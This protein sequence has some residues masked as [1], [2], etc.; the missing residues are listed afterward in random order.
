MARTKGKAKV[1]K[2]NARLEALNVQYIDVSKIIPNSYNP[3]RQSDS[4]F[5]LLR[6]SMNEDG[7]TQPIV[8]V[9]GD[10]KDTYRIVDGEHRWRC[11][12]ELGYEEV[13]IVVTPMTIEQARIATL[14][15]NRARGSEDIELS[16][17]VLRD[18]EKLGAIDWAKDS[19]MMTEAELNKLLEDIPAPEALANEVYDEAWVPTQE[20]SDN[21]DY[22]E[23]ETDDGTLVRSFSPEALDKQRKLEKQLAEARTE[24][25]RVMAQR[26]QKFYRVNLVYADQEAKI[27]K[28]VLGDN[29]A[30][31]FLELATE[32]YKN[33]ASQKKDQS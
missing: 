16:A 23:M 30:K 18:L 11:A 32:E 8:C 24:E 12:Q 33:I 31:K 29:P 28:Y 10:V 1:K 20:S 2:E 14:R 26:S 22:K 21:P 5:E 13:P 3:N 6:R 25:E 17:Q 19:L 4:E 15:H 9:E 7:F 27:V